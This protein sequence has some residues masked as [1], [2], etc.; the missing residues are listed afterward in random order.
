MTGTR[1]FRGKGG[2]RLKRACCVGGW[3][4]FSRHPIFGQPLVGGL[5]GWGFG[6]LVLVEG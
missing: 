3:R 1:A 6:P 2:H 4:S 5:D